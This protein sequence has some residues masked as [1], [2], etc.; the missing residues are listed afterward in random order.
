M[1]KFYSVLCINDNEVTLW[2]QKQTIMKVLLSNKIHTYL[3]GQDGI[4]F[5]NT[6][7]NSDLKTGDSFP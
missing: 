7:L 6:F 5:C 4:D 1:A 2:I 3:S